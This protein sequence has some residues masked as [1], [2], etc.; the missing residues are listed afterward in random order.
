MRFYGNTSWFEFSDVI[1]W[2]L[3][4]K[5]RKTPFF[6]L[7]LQF[8]M[9]SMLFSAKEINTRANF[10]SYDISCQFAA[11][12]SRNLQLRDSINL[13]RLSELT[14]LYHILNYWCL[15][16]FLRFFFF[17]KEDRNLNFSPFFWTNKWL[18]KIS[19]WHLVSRFTINFLGNKLAKLK[20]ILYFFFCWSDEVCQV[21]LLPEFL[22]NWIQI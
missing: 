17:T 9:F 12:L 5:L 14:L 22:G 4:I 6:V 18:S 2:G 7:L 1:H 20:L 16:K 15:L 11:Q 13:G 3:G 19:L 8:H 10:G 21:W